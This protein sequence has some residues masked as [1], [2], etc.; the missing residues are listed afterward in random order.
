MQENWV[1]SLYWEDPLEKK[2]ATHSSI[3]AWRIPRIEEPMDKES[4]APK[5]C[6]FWTVVLENTLESPLDFLDIQPVH[7]KKKSLLIIFIGRTHA[8]AE[9]PTLWPPDAKNWLTGKDPDSGKDWREEE[10]GWKRMRWLDSIINSMDMSLSKLQ[11][12]VTDREAWC[13]ACHP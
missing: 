4:W 3:L 2:M 8:E 10:N 12:L 6:C 9:T 5:N 11:K 13:A 7:P 1:Q